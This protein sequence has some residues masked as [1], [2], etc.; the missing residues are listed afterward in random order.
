MAENKICAVTELCAHQ[1]NFTRVSIASFIQCNPWFDG[2][3]YLLCTSNLE[4]LQSAVKS[5]R[6]IYLNIVPLYIELDEE[7]LEALRV[8]KNNLTDDD[9]V[10]F[11]YLSLFK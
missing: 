9:R 10:S 1:V 4:T 6:K 11:A 7:V 2:P 3:I 8:N 5:I